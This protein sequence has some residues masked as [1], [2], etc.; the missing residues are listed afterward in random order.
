M[1]WASL[2]S[3]TGFIII[4]NL[5]ICKKYMIMV[6]FCRD[7]AARNCLVGDN[8]L[9]KVA[10]FGLA[11]LMQDDTYTAHAGSQYFISIYEN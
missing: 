2:I 5:I 10:D 7:L 11:R 8:H 3:Y 4:D 6:C 1:V 9:V